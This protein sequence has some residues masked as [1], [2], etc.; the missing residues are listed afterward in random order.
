MKVYLRP[1]V[2]VPASAW[3]ELAPGIWGKRVP[4]TAIPKPTPFVIDR[5][6]FERTLTLERLKR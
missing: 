3:V 2:C 1:D 5:D 6:L 4:G